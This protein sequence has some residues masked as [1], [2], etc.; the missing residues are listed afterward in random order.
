MEN[1]TRNSEQFIKSTLGNKNP[2]ATPD[3]YFDAIEDQ[4]SAKLA[5]E[6]FSKENPFKVSDK[7][8]DSLEDTILAKVHSGK[9]EVKVISLKDRLLKAIPFAAAAS[10]IL[11]I[12]LNTFNFKTDNTASLDSLSDA[13]I[14]YWLDSN[15]LHTTDIASV[16]EDDL[17]DENAFY[18]TDIEDESIE[19]YINT[20]DNSYLLNELK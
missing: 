6:S 4:F 14:E 16:L 12:G 1:E 20:D 13:D 18:F 3:N 15:T 11:F 5:E 17:L 7:Y 8:F 2:F 9:K 10:I 19:D